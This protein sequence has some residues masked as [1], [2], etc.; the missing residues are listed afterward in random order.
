MAVTL[1]IPTA[2]RAFTDGQSELALDGQ[3]VNE[4]LTALI[5]RYPDLGLHLYDPAGN[6]RSFVN[7]Y[8]NNINI[9]EQAGLDTPISDKDQ[10]ILVPAIAGGHGE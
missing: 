5:A 4:L 10:V 7:L 9:K 6:L 3:N 8:V 2:L 1:F